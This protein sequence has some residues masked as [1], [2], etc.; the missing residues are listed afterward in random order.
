[1]REAIR[2]ALAPFATPAGVRLGY[3]A[4]VATAV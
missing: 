3:A 1:V 2:A 4:W